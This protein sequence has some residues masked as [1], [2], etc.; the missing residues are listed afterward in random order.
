M[1]AYL[2]FLHNFWTKQDCS[3]M[4]YYHD[5]LSAFVLVYALN[6]PSVMVYLELSDDLAIGL[7]EM[8]RGIFKAER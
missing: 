2:A 8:S 1:K 5:P 6:R 4:Q 7:P 3:G